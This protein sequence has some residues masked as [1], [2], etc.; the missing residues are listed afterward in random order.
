[1]L[2]IGTYKSGDGLHLLWH[3]GQ[4]IFLD[5]PLQKVGSHISTN[6]YSFLAVQCK[7]QKHIK[8]QR[9]GRV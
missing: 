9:C 3:W 2:V 6:A 7:E 8:A 5:F 4:R 1:M